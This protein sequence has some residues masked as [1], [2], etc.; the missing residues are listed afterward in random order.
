MSEQNEKPSKS[1]DIAWLDKHE[2]RIRRSFNLN[3]YVYL[4]GFVGADDL[5]KIVQEKDRYVRDVVPNQPTSEVY[6]EIKERPDTLKQIQQMYRHDDFF[7]DLMID[8]PWQRLAEVC[9]GQ[10][11]VAK[12]MQHFNKPPGIGKGTP[13]HQDGYYFHLKPNHAI[14]MWMALEDVE[15]EQGCVNYVQGSHRYGMRAHGRTGTLGFSQGILDFGCEH[16]LRQAMA[17]PCRAG[18]LIAHHSLMIHWAGANTTSDRSRQALGWIYYG[19]ECQEDE[20]AA[21]NYQ[22]QLAK[23]LKT[24][25]KI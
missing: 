23:N 14:T 22:A 7:R 19:S 3:G 25:S 11:A 20:V 6:Y 13:P 4:P 2:E 1:I 9:L 24:E 15:P 10:A 18:D 17:F 12:N 16:D 21:A 8:S 5:E